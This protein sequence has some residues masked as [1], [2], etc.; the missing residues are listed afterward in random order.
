MSAMA[1][2]RVLARLATAAHRALR[3]AMPT[4][5][6]QAL[7][8]T[9]ATRPSSAMSAC[10]ESRRALE[11]PVNHQQALLVMLTQLVTT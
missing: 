3:L 1:V 6:V 9:M 2:G 10:L 11:L 5:P 4:W 8:A 7:R